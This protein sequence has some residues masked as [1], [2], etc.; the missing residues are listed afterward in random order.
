MNLNRLLLVPL[1]FLLL[2][3]E[4]LL[5]LKTGL[6]LH[7]SH[8]LLLLGMLL[9]PSWIQMGLLVGICA[10]LSSFS[11]GAISFHALTLALPTLLLFPLSKKVNLNSLR[12]MSLLL[13]IF[14][15]F[16]NLLLSPPTFFDLLSFS[17]LD[18]LAGVAVFIPLFLAKQIKIYPF[19]LKGSQTVESNFN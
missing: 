7:M 18:T 5:Y 2:V 3:M 6:L 13:L 17:I 16:F 11:K 19:H 15:F 12:G 10:A 14:N 8:A 4:Q 9:M 1:F